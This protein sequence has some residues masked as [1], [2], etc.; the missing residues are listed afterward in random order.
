MSGRRED[1]DKGVAARRFYTPRHDMGLTWMLGR[2]ARQAANV[3]GSVRKFS[4]DHGYRRKRV[5]KRSCSLRCGS[6]S[7]SALFGRKSASQTGAGNNTDNTHDR[8]GI[9]WR[10]SMTASRLGVVMREPVLPGRHTSRCATRSQ[11]RPGE[12]FG[13]QRRYCKFNPPQRLKPGQR[14]RC[15][16]I[17]FPPIVSANST[18]V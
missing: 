6:I 4:D 14:C 10:W 3:S 16:N 18:S 11:Q 2:T 17:P 7:R 1:K 15:S 5:F 8:P 9:C 13:S 12:V